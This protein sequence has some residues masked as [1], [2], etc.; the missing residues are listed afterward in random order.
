MCDLTNER[1]CQ[2]YS[3]GYRSDVDHLKGLEL[4]SLSVLLA[5]VEISADPL[6]RGSNCLLYCH[7]S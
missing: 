4:D 1:L 3:T 2:P 5:C 7:E 6:D